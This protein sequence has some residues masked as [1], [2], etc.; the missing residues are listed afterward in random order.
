M[1]RTLVSLK[2]TEAKESGNRRGAGKG[3]RNTHVQF[4]IFPRSFTNG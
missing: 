1:Q 3:S 2:E 4:Q